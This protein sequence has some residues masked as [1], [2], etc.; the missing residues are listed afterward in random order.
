MGDLLFVVGKL[1][2]ISDSW[3]AVKQRRVKKVPSQKDL[4]SLLFSFF[5]LLSRVLN[6]QKLAHYAHAG[7]I[8][9]RT[10]HRTSVRYNTRVLPASLDEFGCLKIFG[11]K[12]F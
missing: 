9:G 5:L 2:H 12:T 10:D 4:F 6:S 8:S 1:G 3:N 7:H 11:D